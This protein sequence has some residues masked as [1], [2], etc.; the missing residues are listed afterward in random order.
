MTSCAAP[1]STPVAASSARLKRPRRPG[2][3][4]SRRTGVPT[5][6]ESGMKGFEVTAWQAILAPAKTPA[7]ILQRISAATA[8]VLRQPDVLAKLATQD[9]LAVGSSPGEY[10]VYLRAELERWKNVVRATGAKAE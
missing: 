9:A 3:I 7:D 10:A 5:M 4:P 8:K 1:V 6:D 2:T